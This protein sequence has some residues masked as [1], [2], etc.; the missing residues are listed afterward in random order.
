MHA[1]IRLI[2]LAVAIMLTSV[3]QSDPTA[4][5][6]ADA[7]ATS[8]D[9]QAAPKTLAARFEIR[10]TDSTG[11]T[12]DK[13]E[14]YWVREPNRIE[15]L[16]PNLQ[17]AE[18][19]ERNERGDL[20]LRRIFPADRRVVEYQP[21]D[22]RAL[23]IEPTW[24]SLGSVLDPRLLGQLKAAGVKKLPEGDALTYAGEIDGEQ[25]EVWWLEDAALPA[26][27]VRRKDQREFTLTLQALFSTPP[28]DWPRIRASVM[29]DYLVIDAADLGDM[30]YDPFVHKLEQFDATTQMFG[31]EAGHGHH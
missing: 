4:P 17:I 26:R 14:W 1:F 3:A 24:S 25:L 12:V 20:S 29:S 13:G 21:G 11:Q 9:A 22:L 18:V 15:T 27:L 16:R 8:K 10:I 7:P 6:G 31:R 19:W 5:A 28:V 23:H 2:L 30:H